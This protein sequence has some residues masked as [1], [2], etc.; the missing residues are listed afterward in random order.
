MIAQHFAVNYPEMV[1]RLVLAVTSARANSY[2]RDL[3]PAWMDMAKRDD[4]QELMTDNMMK[5]YSEEYIRKNKWTLRIVGKVGKPKSYER[6][7]I[8]A[9]ACMNHDCYDMLDRIQVPT[10][11][12]GG[13]KDMVVG[14]QSA[15]E[16][17]DR[18]PGAMLKTYPQ[19][20]HALYEE[21]KDLNNVVLEFLKK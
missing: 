11:V 1:G 6:F 7:L 17:A 4:F 19:Y 2:I 5:M 8:M 16:I 10:L 3:I 15:L 14:P 12:I 18:I 9:E 20:G 13:E 21:A